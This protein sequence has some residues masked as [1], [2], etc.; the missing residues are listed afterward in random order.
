MYKNQLIIPED[1]GKY[2]ELIPEFYHERLRKGELFAIASY[3]SRFPRDLLVGVVIMGVRESWTQ[4]LWLALTEAYDTDDR[5]ED[6]VRERILDAV[7]DGE[8]EG[9]F[10]EFPASFGKDRFFSIFGSLD[11]RTEEISGNVLEFTLGSIHTDKL[12]VLKNDHGV[13]S[14][15][16]A[17]TH[18]LHELGNLMANDERL[19]PVEIPV[20]WKSYDQDLSLIHMVDNMPAGLIL[21]TSKEKAARVELAYEN[22]PKGILKLVSVLVSKALEEKDPDTLITIAILEE[23]L[24]DM[25]KVIVP[26][27]KRPDILKGYLVF[28]KE[29]RLSPFKDYASEE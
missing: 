24:F 4:I 1:I 29:E 19:I 13:I 25:I 6:L 20:S 28:E 23:K 16:E 11:F 5:A 3:E 21:V 14:L 26:D 17:D 12:P 10:V 18:I 2:G 7:Q 15:K 8:A 22:T 9:I 27:A